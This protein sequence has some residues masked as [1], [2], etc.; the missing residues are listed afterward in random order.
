MPAG[1][2]HD[3][4]SWQH[5]V[6]PNHLSAGKSI[7]SEDF[8]WGVR[9]AASHLRLTDP[10]TLLVPVRS[11]LLGV[12]LQC[13]APPVRCMN[14]VCSCVFKLCGFWPSLFL[15]A[16]SPAPPERGTGVSLRPL[17]SVGRLLCSLMWGWS[18]RWGAPHVWMPHVLQREREQQRAVLILVLT[19]FYW[20]NQEYEK[21]ML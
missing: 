8:R 9:P 16:S 17:R 19:N 4:G 21:N 14:S 15:S 12:W 6:W 3:R 10:N 20:V 18:C 7:I 11:H 5:L 2:E 1:C 13:K